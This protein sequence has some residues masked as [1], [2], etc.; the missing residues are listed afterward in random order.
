MHFEEPIFQQ[1]I[2]PVHKSKIICN[3]FGKRVESTG[4]LCIQFKFHSY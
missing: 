2:A 4:M 1:Y 3:F